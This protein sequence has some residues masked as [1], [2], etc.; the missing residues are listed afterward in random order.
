MFRAWLQLEQVYN[1]NEPDLEVWKIGAEHSSRSQ[2]FLSGN[3]SRRYQ[4]HIGLRSLVVAGPIPYANA[5][6]AVP[7]R[8]VHVH[9]L[10]VQLL[11]A[12]N[13]V[14]VVLA[15]QTVVGD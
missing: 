12:D 7:D 14:D 6:G 13:H 3:I 2:R 9:V 1:V 5:F 8:G 15:A 10:Q 11:I 4:H